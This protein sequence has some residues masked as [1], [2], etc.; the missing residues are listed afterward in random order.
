MRFILIVSI[1]LSF[2]LQA[3]EEVCTLTELELDTD[4]PIAEQ[5][6]YTG[7]CHYR[8]ENYEMA[9]KYWS[10]LTT[11]P[12]IPIEFNEFKI[13]ANNNLGYLLFFGYGIK[14]DKNQALKHWKYA[15]SLGHS[16]SEYHLC[17]AYADVKQPTY[18]SGKAPMHCK[19]AKLIY[20]GIEEPDEDEKIMLEH[21][22]QYLKS[23]S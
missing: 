6:F 19:K 23:L 17:H 14:A 21:I 16:E 15:I 8:H 7:T 20:Q 9:A 12:D 3:K 2:G 13:D 1:L 18:N 4:S 10:E 5:L 11:A 22:K